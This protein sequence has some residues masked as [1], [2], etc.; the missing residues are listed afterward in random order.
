MMSKREDGAPRFIGSAFSIQAYIIGRIDSDVP[1][2]Y[3]AQG[4]LISPFYGYLP[5]R[6]VCYIFIVLFAVSVGE[7]DIWMRCST[8]ADTPGS[9]SLRTGYPLP[10]LVAPPDRRTRSD[11]RG[12]RVVGTVMVKLQPTYGHTLSNT[13]SCGHMS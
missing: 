12:H 11:R 5:T 9:S 1:I 7:F 8:S 10:C 3:D 2:I 4:H 13:V 6:S